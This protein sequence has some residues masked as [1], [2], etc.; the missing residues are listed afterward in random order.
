M[1]ANIDLYNNNSIYLLLTAR[2]QVIT[3]LKQLFKELSFQTDQ[4]I[5]RN[6]AS[7]AFSGLVRQ[8]IQGHSYKPSWLPNKVLAIILKK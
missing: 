3:M 7:R 4:P 1:H 8:R 5:K 6:A 2:N